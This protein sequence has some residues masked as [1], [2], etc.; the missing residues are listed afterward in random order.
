MNENHIGRVYYLFAAAAVGAAV[1]GLE[2]LA[3]RTMAP[4]IGTGSVAWSALLAVALGSLA[5]GNL[6]GGFLAAGRV[7]PG[8][9]VVWSLVI[10]SAALVGLSQAHRP[11][12]AWA[13][14]QS[15]LA[16][17]IIAAAATQVVPM[18]TLGIISPVILTAGR[19]PGSK[20]R[21]AGV[22][23]ATGSVGSIAG[24]LVM[25]LV[26]LPV[27]G[28][29]RSYLVVAVLLAVAAGPVV[30]P[31]RRWL[32]GLLAAGAI[33]ASAALWMRTPTA[34]IIQS[35]YGQIEIRTTDEQKVLLIDGLA[36][37]AIPLP[38]AVACWDGLHHGYLLEL[39]LLLRPGM[40]DALVIGLGAGLAPRLLSAHGLTCE[41]V[42]IDP[43]VVKIARSEFGFD[44]QVT[45]A[46]GRS[47]LTR[48][49][50]KWDLIFLDVCTCD[51]LAVHLFTVEA[52][53]TVRGRLNTGGIL[54]IQFIGG[55]GPWSA[56]LAR[57]V[58]EVFGSAS[59]LA[60]TSLFEDVGPRWIF[61]STVPLPPIGEV[62][63]GP[64]WLVPWRSILP[65]AD[66]QLLSDDHFPAELD[67][68][69]TAA[70]WRTLYA[71]ARAHAH[72]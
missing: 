9:A 28:L 40:R 60:A 43:M 29:T 41:S 51:R 69:R 36:Q 68:A 34:K 4:A 27:I 65:V 62:S 10:A 50:N 53:R 16:G 71:V 55:D 66:G 52:L 63:A 30:L 49:Q 57:T 42:E 12:M 39:S 64:E 59:M 21:W 45:V 32:A 48:T 2:V 1:L 35:R 44:D 70:R 31:E 25:G 8:G 23:L 22:V 46:D 5:A 56:G 20:G 13:A 3:G 15:L 54:A 67:W 14:D 26:L 58:E 19:R 72:P 24:A 17:A 6:I 61:A 37:T 33:V 18:L 47:F 38:D 7:R 11:A